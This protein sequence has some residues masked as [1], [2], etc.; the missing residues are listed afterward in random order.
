MAMAAPSFLSILLLLAS[1]GGTSTN[2]LLSLMDAQDYFQARK[3][4]VKAETML[5]LASKEPADT[6]AQVQQLLAIRWLGEN[7]DQASK[8]RN[9]RETLRQIAEGEKAQ[10]RL[11]FAQKYAKRSL[12]LLD[13]K[14]APEHRAI[15][16]NSL[17]ADALRWFPKDATMVGGYDLRAAGGIKP[18][19]EVRLRKLVAGMVPPREK[20]QAY[21][22]IEKLGN[23]HLDRYSMAMY[24]DPQQP[25]KMRMVMRLTG[26]A[27]RKALTKTILDGMKQA[28]TVPVR[29]TGNESISLITAD[30]ED[31][32]LAPVCSLAT[33]RINCGRT[34]SAGAAHS[35]WPRSASRP[36][37]PG[38]RRWC[39]ART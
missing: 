39:C 11:G 38:K 35:K 3:I 8:V 26:L 20:E 1:V 33:S 24:L 23:V 27:D 37:W 16:N 5:A 2:D 28:R 29:G 6:K 18:L 7:P 4:E 15:P 36:L 12:A 19:D 31:T 14:P 32:A 30:K 9:A 13:G 21:A 17:R 22:F 10:G 34:W 25:E